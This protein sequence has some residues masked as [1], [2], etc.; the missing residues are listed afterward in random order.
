[1]QELEVHD[2]RFEKEVDESEF[3]DALIH[4]RIQDPT[5]KNQ[6]TTSSIHECSERRT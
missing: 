2:L 6:R 3:D 4:E 5:I 1:M